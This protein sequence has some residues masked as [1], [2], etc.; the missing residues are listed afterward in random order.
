MARTLWLALLLGGAVGVLAGVYLEAVHLTEQLI[1]DGTD[2]RLPG[3]GAWQVVLVCAAGGL[4]VGVLRLRHDRDTPNDLEDALLEL[5][6]ALGEDRKPPPKAS[7]LI[8]ATVLGVV[9]L[10]FGASLGPEAPLIAIATGFGDRIG[11]IL[12]VSR[13]EAALITSSGAISG[14]FGGPLAAVA[15]PLERGRAAATSTR[16]IGAG[17]VAGLAGLVTMLLVLPER[18]GGRYVL[19]YADPGSGRDLVES[20][21]WAAAGAVPAACAGLLLLLGTEPVRRTAERLVPSTV[22]RAAAGG[23]VLGVCGAVEGLSLFS[24]EHEGQE[25]IDSAGDKAATAFLLIALLKVV[26]TLACLGTGWFGGQIFPSVFIGMATALAVTAVWDS[27]PVGAVVAAGAGAAAT[28]VLRRPLATV[29]ILL[30][31][32]PFGAVLPL[33]VG[34]GVGALVSGLSPDRRTPPRR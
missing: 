12:R 16:L 2:P 20:I 34:A 15:L 14:L 1:W 22:L 29:L 31:F 25:L 32:F 30:F 9:S 11:R 23:L 6:D 19:P 33:A 21:G 3:D 8:R 5:D 7:W 10:A 24:G 4:L 27:A 28:A 17:L 13:A 26:A 18:A